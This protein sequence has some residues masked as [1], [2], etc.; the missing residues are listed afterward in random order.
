M[1]RNHIFRFT[2]INEIQMNI[3]SYLW[4]AAVLMAASCSSPSSQDPLPSWNETPIKQQLK[5]YIENQA[6]R[7]PVEDRIAV[8]DMDG[9]IA[10]ERPLW[11][12]MAVAVQR[13]AE[14]QEQHPELKQ[15]TE[16]QYAAKLAQNPT[17]TSVLNNWFLNGENYLD[18]ILFKAFEGM[19]NEAYVTYARKFLQQQEAPKYG[20][21]ADLFYQPMLELIEYLKKKDFQVYIVSGSMQGIVWSICPQT[22]GVDRSRLIG[23][24]QA[25]EVSFNAGQP[26]TYTLKKGVELPKNNYYGKSVNIYNRIGKIPVMAIGNTTGDFGMFHLAASST[27]PHFVMML[28]HDDA[29]REYA[30]EPFYEGNPN[31]KDSLSTYR[32]IQADMSKEFKTVWR[33][34]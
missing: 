28:N 13:M 5:D 3:K 14:Q 17:D 30:Y 34:R 9:T 12:E 4:T 26:A 2:L 32:W 25:M 19:D 18:S 8:F 15:L 6:A 23:T 21:Y 10:C 11:F 31:W 20:K 7:I 1:Q 24:R 33:T 27:Y 22:I 29:H 16:Y